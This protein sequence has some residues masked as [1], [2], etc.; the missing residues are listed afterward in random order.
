MIHVCA[1]LHAG[2]IVSLEVSG[3]AGSAEK[4][5]D[6]VCAAVSAISFGLCN[7]LDQSGSEAEIKVESNRIRIQASGSD[8]NTE[9][10]LRTGLIQLK[11]VEETNGS[12]LN[13]QTLE[14]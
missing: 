1:K 9:T 3:H 8:Q 7:A 4:G 5:K 13:I 10:I 2:Q 6:L 11:T 14:V 12:Y